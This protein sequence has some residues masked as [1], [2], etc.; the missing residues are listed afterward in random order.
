MHPVPET[1]VR[2]TGRVSMG[3]I[4]INLSDGDQVVGMQMNTQGEYLLVV[5]E[6]RNGQDDVDQRIQ[7]LRTE[8]ARASSAI[9]SW[10]KQ[11]MWWE[12][13]L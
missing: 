4:G 7:S 10:K 13:R 3:V 6:K 1:D 5:S 11:E 12:P 9:K 8:A 2:K